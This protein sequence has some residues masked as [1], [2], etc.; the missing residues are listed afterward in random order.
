MSNKVWFITGASRGFG[1]IWA[2]GALARGDKVVATARS[3]ESLSDLARTYGDAVLPLALDVTK[4]EQVEAV[5][6]KAH[7]HFGRLDVVINNAG[8]ALLGAVEE[9]TEADVR[10]QFETNFFGALAVIQTVLPLLRKQ[11]SGHILGVSSVSGVHARAVTSFYNASKWAFEALHEGLSQEV[12]ELG[13]KVT[14][15]EPGAYATDFGSPSSLKIAPGLDVYA[16]IRTELFAYGS[17]MELGDPQATLPAVLKVID[18]EHPPLRIFLGTEG[19]PVV[20]AAFAERLALWE[21]WE[22]TSNAAQGVSRKLTLD[23]V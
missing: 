18:A 12:A 5:I 23:Y 22:A 17:Q 13:I 8:Y 7:A 14:L 2:D 15:I 1:R 10:A 3:A 11:G 6:P 19:M 9:A 21:A 20:R 16:G 4:R